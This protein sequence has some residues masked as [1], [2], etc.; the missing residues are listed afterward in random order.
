MMGKP[1]GRK[2]VGRTRPKWVDNITMDLE[3]LGWVD[4]H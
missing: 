2:P 3:E 4:V 1:E